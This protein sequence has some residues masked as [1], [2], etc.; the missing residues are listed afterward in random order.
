MKKKGSQYKSNSLVRVMFR[1]PVNHIILTLYV[2]I[3]FSKLG[4]KYVLGEQKFQLLLSHNL[5]KYR[6]QDYFQN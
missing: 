1:T 6:P 4:K 5:L 3:L 2:G